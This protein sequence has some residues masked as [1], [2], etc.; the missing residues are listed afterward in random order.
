MRCHGVILFAF[1]RKYEYNITFILPEMFNMAIINM[2]CSL[3]DPQTGK[4]EAYFSNNLW[5]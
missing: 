5:Y 3:A 2:I 4:A 1:N